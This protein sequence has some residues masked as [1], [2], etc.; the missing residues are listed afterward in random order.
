MTHA[1]S[2]A[3]R[4]GDGRSSASRDPDPLGR[5]S[6][7]PQEVRRVAEEGQRQ[8]HQARCF[9]KIERGDDLSDPVPYLRKGGQ[10]RRAAAALAL[11][12]RARQGG[13]HRMM[14]P[15]VVTAAFEVIEAQVVFEFPIVLFNRPAPAGQ[16]H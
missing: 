4:E 5:G 9:D 11:E 12:K 15:A 6:V 13:D 7:R 14:V 3:S 16:A 2:R 10:G 1:R 8:L